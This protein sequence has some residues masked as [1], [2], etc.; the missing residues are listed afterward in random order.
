MAIPISSSLIQLNAETF[1]Q[2]GFELSLD[3][4]VQRTIELTGS[5]TEF[6][7]KTQFYIYDYT[8]TILVYKFRLYK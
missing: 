5:F 1:F 7:S 2:E 4:I 6:K 8:K 3:A